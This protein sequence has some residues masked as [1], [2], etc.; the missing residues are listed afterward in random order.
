MII[1]SS[2]GKQFT[3]FLLTIHDGIQID[4]TFTEINSFLEF[5]QLTQEDKMMVKIQK[6]YD[7][8]KSQKTLLVRD[9]IKTLPILSFI[10]C[11]LTEDDNEVIDSLLE[12]LHID[13]FITFFKLRK[14]DNALSDEFNEKYM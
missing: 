2:A 4:V 8:R 12:Q 14:M 1:R 6:I 9:K 5:Q 11:D 10:Q 13:D 7:Q 3:T